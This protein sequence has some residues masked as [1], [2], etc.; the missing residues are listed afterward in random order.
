MS[1][2][3][4]SIQYKDIGGQAV[5]EGVMMQSPANES[6]AIAVRRPS[7]RIVVTCERNGKRRMVVVMGVK[8]GDHG[9]R[10]DELAKKLLE[11][12]YQP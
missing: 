8:P 9:R 6:I 2:K 3:K 5:M 7:G 12:S 11:W 10:R 4:H 1:D